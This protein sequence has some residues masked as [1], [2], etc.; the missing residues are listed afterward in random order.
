MPQ[1]EILSHFKKFLTSGDKRTQTA[2]KNISISFISKGI[3]ILVSFLIVPL[4]LSYVTK[5][6]YGIWMTISS[7]VQWFSFFD[8]GL[9]NGLRNKLAEALAR[10]DENKAK[11]YISSTFF[12]ISI[13]SL[14][15]LLAFFI[16]AQFIS[17]NDVLNTNLIE[18]ERLEEIVVLVFFFFCMD[19]ILKIFTNILQAQQR[20]A[21]NDIVSIIVQ[22]SGLLALYVLIK[23]TNGSLFNLCF[24]YAGK[25]PFIMIITGVV[26]FAGI[27]KKYIPK[28]RYVSIKE[29]IP[30]L[31]LGFKFFLNQILFI[32]VTQSSVII[33]IQFFGPEDVTVFNLAVRYISIGSMLY[34]MVL[35]PF[36]TAFTEAYTVNDF[37]WI[38]K[39]MEK[40]RRIWIAVSVFTLFLALGYQIFFKLW[41]GDKLEIPE[42]LI[43]FLTISQIINTSYNGY[44]LFLNGIGKIKLQLYLLLVQAIA[45]IPL[46]YLFYELGMGLSSTVLAQVTLYSITAIFIHRQYRLLINKEAVGVWNA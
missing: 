16:G 5:V 13:I 35:T 1:I 10:G 30:L 43:I 3:S 32:L 12:L 36:L 6:E 46:S 29:S 18:N 21:F 23:T 31:N 19:F 24:V 8:I 25:S 28:W 20:Y 4:T 11:V 33:V 34:M 44:S 14:G 15:M 37:E 39:S 9:G 26:L 45:F 40:I 17:W 42:H 27:L 2:K 41:V 7:I 22:L 38:R